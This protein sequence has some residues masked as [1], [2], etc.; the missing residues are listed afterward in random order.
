MVTV[1]HAVDDLA[2]VVQG[3]ALFEAAF[4]D[5]IVEEFSAFN[6]F[7]NEIS[8]EVLGKKKNFC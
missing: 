7:E 3:L 6:V 1:I 8:K 5:E 4:A 2:E